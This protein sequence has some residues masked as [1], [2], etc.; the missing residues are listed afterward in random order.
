MWEINNV[1]H[2][3]LTKIDV[4]RH[5]IDT[6]ANWQDESHRV[7][8]TSDWG[9]PEFFPSDRCESEQTPKA[10]LAGLAS[11]EPIRL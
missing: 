4:P 6:W 7:I 5:F 8:S 2:M 11:S 1:V 10:W 9:S 3:G